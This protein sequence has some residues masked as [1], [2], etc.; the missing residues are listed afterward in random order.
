MSDLW[1]QCLINF[2][3]Q[4][5]SSLSLAHQKHVKELDGVQIAMY[6]KKYGIWQGG[7]EPG[8]ILA[9]SIELAYNPKSLKGF[10]TIAYTTTL[11][12]N[13]ARTRLT[14]K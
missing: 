13:I 8:H 2:D 12:L 14:R 11:T 9:V 6:K 3:T 10:S 1:K 4:F 7:I 5:L